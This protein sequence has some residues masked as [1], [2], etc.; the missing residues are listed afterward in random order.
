[1]RGNIP[2]NHTNFVNRSDDISRTASTLNV[3]AGIWLIISSWV[4]GYAALVAPFWNTLLVGI[5]VLLV[6]AVRLGTPAAIGLS[7]VNFLLGIW[8]IISPWVVGFTAASTAMGNDIV[9]G[10]LVG[11]FGLWAALGTRTYVRT[12]R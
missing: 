5:A 12:P 11:I 4:L 1:M 10:I 3:F 6:A 2:V 9:L 8:L 7:W